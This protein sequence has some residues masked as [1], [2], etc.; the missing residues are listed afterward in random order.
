[1]RIRR[2]ALPHDPGLDELVGRESAFLAEL[3]DR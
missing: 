2:A 3:E 1:M